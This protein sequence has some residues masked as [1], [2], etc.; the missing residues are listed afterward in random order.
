[1]TRFATRTARTYAR[2][3]RKGVGATVAPSDEGSL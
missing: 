1:V 3:P 2:L